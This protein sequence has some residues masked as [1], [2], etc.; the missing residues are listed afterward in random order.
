MTLQN[1]LNPHMQQSEYSQAQAVVDSSGRVWSS[2]PDSSLGSR[3]ISQ[4]C[5][6]YT[7]ATYPVADGGGAN[8]GGAAIRGQAVGASADGREAAPRH[9]D[10]LDVARGPARLQSGKQR[11]FVFF[12][13]FEDVRYC[14]PAIGASKVDIYPQVAYRLGNPHCICGKS[15]GE[16]QGSN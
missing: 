8:R 13:F 15:R 3:L 1:P 7:P 4:F 9:I 5:K 12:F 14:L 2:N 16:G 6:W 11:S 10:K